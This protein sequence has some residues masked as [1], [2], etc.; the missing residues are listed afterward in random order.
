L[1][2]ISIRLLSLAAAGVAHSTNVG[3]HHERAGALIDIVTKSGTAGLGE[4]IAEKQSSLL[5]HLDI[6]FGQDVNWM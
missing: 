6:L 1:E 4:C 3:E 2:S 5:Q